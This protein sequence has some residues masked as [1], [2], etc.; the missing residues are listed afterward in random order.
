MPLIA[1]R[2]LWFSST[3]TNT[4][5]M[6]DT[7]EGDGVADAEGVGDDV[8]IDVSDAVAAGEVGLGLPVALGAPLDVHPASSAPQAA[9]DSSRASCLTRR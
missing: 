4:L 1:E 2:A 5:L 8:G 6:A 9:R 3:T 7:G